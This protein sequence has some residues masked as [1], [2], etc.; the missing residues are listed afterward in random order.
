M[1]KQT[2]LGVK[3]VEAYPEERDGKPG[4]AVI[5]PDGYKS[6]SP[7]DVFEAAY[8]PIRDGRFIQDDDI[9]AFIDASKVDIQ[10]NPG[11]VMVKVIYPNGLTD[12]EGMASSDIEGFDYHIASVNCMH[13]I[14]ERLWDYMVFVMSWAS[15]GLKIKGK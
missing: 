3:R 7:K 1:E 8:F 9:Q 10:V 12:V 2:Y 4:Y 13:K 14:R 6:W 5:Y 15:D 11:Q